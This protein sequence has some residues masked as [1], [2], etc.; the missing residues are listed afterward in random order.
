MTSG[1]V[2]DLVSWDS[3]VQ[4]VPQYPLSPK[5]QEYYTK[6]KI[7]SRFANAE[8][9]DAVNQK[10][11]LEKAK[12]EISIKKQETIEKHRRERENAVCEICQTE[13]GELI[14]LTTYPGGEQA[15]S[16]PVFSVRYLVI[17]CLNCADESLGTIQRIRWDG[18]NDVVL[19]YQKQCNPKYFGK[20][21]LNQG[22]AINLSRRRRDGIL[23]KVYAFLVANAVKKEIPKNYG[24]N[25]M[26]SGEWVFEENL[27]KTM[28]GM[29]N[30]L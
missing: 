5:M 8:H 6:K 16:P 27:Q 17:E 11:F 4:N 2:A 1:N 25:R 30:A 21:L 15:I 23:E 18:C 19:L 14:V 12:A 9:Q 26:K 22:I 3:S 10:I 20:R 24:W 13:K 29:V 7:D 28:E